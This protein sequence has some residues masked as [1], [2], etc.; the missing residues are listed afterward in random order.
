MVFGLCLSSNI[1]KA[2]KH[3]VFE[4]GSISFFR[5]AKGEDIYFVGSLGRTN[6][7][8]WTVHVILTTAK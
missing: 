3:S 2:R 5:L 1:L 6:L 4:T 8:H 7:S